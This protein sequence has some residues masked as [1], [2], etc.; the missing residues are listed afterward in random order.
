LEDGVGLVPFLI[1]WGDTLHP[2]VNAPCGVTFV[3]MRAEHPEPA[4]VSASLEA[5][6]VELSVELA[7]LPRL[8]AV[9]LG[10]KGEI[11]LS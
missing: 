3:S 8:L 2:A 1:D 11:T 9:V 4:R 7:P 10:E 6:D 5:L